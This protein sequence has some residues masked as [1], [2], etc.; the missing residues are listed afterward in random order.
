MRNPRTRTTKTFA[1]LL[2]VARAVEHLRS[3][4]ESLMIVTPSS[5]NKATALRDAVLRAYETGLADPGRLKIVAVVP[6]MAREKL[7]SSPLTEEAALGDANPL[8]VYE[9][10]QAEDVKSLAR[11]AVE[12]EGAAILE[13]H[14]MRLWYTLDLRN[15][16][17]ADTVRAFFERDFL[18]PVPG[19]VHAHAVSSAFGLLGH[20]FGRQLAGGE[21]WPEPSAQYFLVQHLGTPDMVASLHH[22]SA[23]YRPSWTYRDGQHEQHED[24]HFPS[25]TYDPGEMLDATFY[26]HR[27]AT[28]AR[29]NEIIHRQGG[30]GI[31]VSLVECLQRYGQVRALVGGT[32]DLPTDPRRLREWS[33]VM[34]MTGVLNAIDRDLL[35]GDDVLIHG[36]GSYHTGDFT[37]PAE[38]RLRPV[39]GAEDLGRLLHR[40]AAA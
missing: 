32:V 30:G 29:M 6:G 3:T 2:I 24:P 25:I 1:S 20:F 8:A 16:A 33:F 21:A 14:G 10:A 11:A 37:P 28:S 5:A 35:A 26:S 39:T 38:S 17:P 9:T 23:D 15:Y 40:A 36:S 7:W 31:V 4:G 12:Q 19:R 22:G 27:P 13:R 18:Q 34:A